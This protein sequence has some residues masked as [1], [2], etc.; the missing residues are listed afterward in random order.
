MA[1]FLTFLIKQKKHFNHQLTIR[2]SEME[3]NLVMNKTLLMKA[4]RN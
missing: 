4:F 2:Y 1:G 3:S